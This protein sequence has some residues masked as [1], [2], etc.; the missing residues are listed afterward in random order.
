MQPEEFPDIKQINQEKKKKRTSQL[1]GKVGAKEH[2]QK[3]TQQHL[4]TTGLGDEKP[5]SAETLAQW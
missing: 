1:Q 5:S 4:R 2:R 3:E